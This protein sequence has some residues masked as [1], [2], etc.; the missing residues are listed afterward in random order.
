MG[1]RH[2]ETHALVREAIEQLR[3]GEHADA[4]TTLERCAFPKW[5]SV[6]DSQIDYL[7]AVTPNADEATIVGRVFGEAML[8]EAAPESAVA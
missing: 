2:D 3:R 6:E 1:S 7:M 5:D 8:R 4:L